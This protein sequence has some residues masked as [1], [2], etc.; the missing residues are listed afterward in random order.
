MLHKEAGATARAIAVQE[1][2]WLV[3]G[4]TEI[5]IFAKN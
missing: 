5:W 1:K 3:S 4:A 2:S